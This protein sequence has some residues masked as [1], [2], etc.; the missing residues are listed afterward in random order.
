MVGALLE[1][2]KYINIWTWPW[3]RAKLRSEV[4]PFVQSTS[5]VLWAF[6][7]TMIILAGAE[8]SSRAVIDAG[9]QTPAEKLEAV[10]SAAGDQQG[11]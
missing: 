10:P 7:A 5:I 2:S 11:N 1:V 9:A 6:V 3:L 8:A 4:P